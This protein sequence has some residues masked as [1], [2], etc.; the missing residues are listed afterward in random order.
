[1]NAVSYFQ[2]HHEEMTAWRH[3]LHSKPGLLF[4]VQDAADFVVQKLRNFG[5]DEIAQE[6]GQTGVVAIIKGKPGGPAYRIGLRADMDALPIHERNEIAHRS[7]VAGKMHAC[8][9]DGHTTMLLGAARY[10][11]ETRAFHGEVALIFQP[12]EE[13]GVG[14]KAMLDDG[15]MER[16]SI[17]EVYGLHNRP[18]LPLGTFATRPRELMAS[19]DIF[20]IEIE[21]VGAHAARPHL[22]VDPVLVASH[23]HMALQSIVSRVADPLE[24]VVVSVTQIHAGKADNVIP[25]TAVMRGTVRCLQSTIRARAEAHLRQ[26]ATGI[27]ASMG[28]VATVDYRPIVPVTE[29]MPEHA[30]YAIQA[31]S[32][33]VGP[34]KASLEGPLNMGGEDFSYMLQQRPGAHIFIGQGDTKGLHHPEYDFNDAIIPLGCAYW[35]SLVERRCAPA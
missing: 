28:A 25:Q 31:A 34:D 15:L 2:T 4:D 9:H 8:G 32:A 27:A 10:L 19:A 14:A 1:M 17:G 13:G 18:G 21:G 11:A 3:Y 33:V 23:I 35:V 24:N 29:N 7:E 16:F 30:D 22:G 26:I 20:Q 12:A 5:V 6:V